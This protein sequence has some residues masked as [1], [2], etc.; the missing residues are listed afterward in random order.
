MVLLLVSRCKI[1]D[2]GLARSLTQLSDNINETDPKLTDYVATRWY[3]AP[4]ILI[5]NPRYTKGIDMWSLGCILGE[6]LAGKPIFP[7]TSTVNQ[8]EKIMSTIAIPS[9]EGNFIYVDQKFLGNEI[10]FLLEISSICVSGVGSSMI[11]NACNLPRITL[12]SI[13]GNDISGDGVDLLNK[14]LVFNPIKRL[15]AEQ[16]L[17]H[18]YV[19]KFHDE[20]EELDMP[21]NVV[22]PLNDDVRLS[23]DDYRNKLYEFMQSHNSQKHKSV[24]K[25]ILKLNGDVLKRDVKSK[26]CKDTERYLKARCQIKPTKEKPYN[27][28]SEPRL[29]HTYQYRSSLNIK[30]DSKIPQPFS[31]EYKVS[32]DSRKSTLSTDSQQKDKNRRRMMNSKT[33]VYMSFNSYNQSY[34]IITQSALMELKAA[35]LR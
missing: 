23:V 29:G 25:N 6:M 14:L 21:S 26:V 16:A 7:G 9:P 10:Y 5:A 34:G 13:L 15:T 31:G 19:S 20:T 11:K 27:T 30:S 1:A 3:R 35:G 4:E 32:S 2:F 28:Q 24:N 22:I 18:L 17:R 8:V 33:N 12:K